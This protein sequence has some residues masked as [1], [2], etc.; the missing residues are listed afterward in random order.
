[1][2][3][4]P[5]FSWPAVTGAESY[6]LE[7][8]LSPSFNSFFGKRIST[9]VPMITWPGKTLASTTTYYWRVRPVSASGT[10]AWMVGVFTTR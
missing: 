4:V 1:V 6:D 9:P 5:T 2:P 3:V 7:I 10:G 8:S